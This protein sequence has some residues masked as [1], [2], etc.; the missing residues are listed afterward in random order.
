M[1]NSSLPGV[2]VYDVFNN[3]YV[4]IKNIFTDVVE[5]NPSGFVEWNEQSSRSFLK[6]KVSLQWGRVF[7]LILKLA[8]H[9]KCGWQEYSWNCFLSHRGSRGRWEGRKRWKM[10]WKQII[11]EG[12]KNRTDMNQILVYW[13]LLFQRQLTSDD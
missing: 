12:E 2:I 3:C 9:Q 7:C 4:P 8:E 13:F 1:K 11:I 5:S 6:K 10:K